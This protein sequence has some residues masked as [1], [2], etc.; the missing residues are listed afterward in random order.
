MGYDIVSLVP[1]F[2]AAFRRQADFADG[3]LAFADRLEIS[4][5]DYSIDSLRAVDS[6][7][8]FVRE[9]RDE[10][11]NQTYTNTVLA[12]GCYLGEVVRRNAEIRWAWQ[13]FDDY[14]VKHPHMTEL[15]PEGLPTA[16]IL[17]GDSR[18][19][20]TMP[21]NKIAR[22]IEEGP[23]NSTHFYALGMLK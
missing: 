18:D 15:I 11:E 12:A 2:C 21:L 8:E 7:L 1:S 3:E 19:R 9:G 22:F 23:E 6:Y 14:I 16:A 4:L 10:I 20:M 13:N 17:V 5:L